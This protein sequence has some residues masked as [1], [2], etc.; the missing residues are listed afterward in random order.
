MIRAGG[1]ARSFIPAAVAVLLLG[2][3]D[4]MVSAY[5]VLYAADEAGLGPV[6]VGLFVAAPAVGGI[7]LSALAGRL[8]D[9]NPSKVYAMAA[10]AAGALGYAVL[11][12]TTTFLVMMVIA[13]VLVGAVSAAFPQLFALAR[14]VLGDGAAGQRSAPL[15]RSGWSLA[16]AIGPLL[17][18]ALLIAGNYAHLLLVAAG[19]LLITALI[20][21]TIPSPDRPAQQQEKP[22]SPDSPA[23]QSR[24][25]V[26]VL[27]TVS[28]G[29]F[30][31]A[32]FAGSIALP[33]YLTQTLAQPDS[34]VGLLYSACAVIEVIAA[35]ALAWL[36]PRVSQRVVITAAMAVFIGYFPLTVVAQSWE[37]LLIG[38]VARGVGIAVVGAAGIRFFQ[39][40]MTATTGHATTL[41]SN[42]S[43]AGSLVAGVLAGISNQY[44]G[45]PAT[46]LL[47]GATAMA[48]AIT[49]LAATR[50]PA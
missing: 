11:T 37:L 13:V 5:L 30:F 15:L 4:S 35:L 50:P 49:F 47:S 26:V 1:V 46:L 34:I 20:I 2:I 17:G 8:F 32:M 23:P 39:D 24:R 22:S 6:E 16:W 41:F 45:Y 31:T 10:A 48:A 42:A 28:I 12:V 19:L 33:L 25:L 27:L 36:P 44:L 38:Q 21:F 43:T 14:L 18:T 9:R 7:V 3:A 40:L 29:L